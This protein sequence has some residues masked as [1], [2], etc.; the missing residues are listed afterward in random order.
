MTSP[1]CLTGTDRIYEASKKINADLYI[2]IQGDEPLINPDDIRKVIKTSE[3]YPEKIINAMCP[4]LTSEDFDNPSIPK[5]VI[6]QSGKLLFISRSP[7]PVNKKRNFISAMKQVC[8]YSFP[9]DK[10]GLFGQMKNK[11]PLEEIEDIEIL[12]FLEMG[13]DIK[14][15]EVSSSSIAV[16]HP[17]DIEKVLEVLNASNT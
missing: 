10:L 3:K 4:I 14:M 2:N 8:I 5:V 9:S 17:E 15:V 6:S 7:I 11:T 16:D 1:D 13:I 12:R